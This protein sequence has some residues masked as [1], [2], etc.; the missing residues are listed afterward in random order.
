MT[1][2]RPSCALDQ[3]LAQS[4]FAPQT[5]LDLPHASAV[6]LVVVADQMKKAVQRKHSPLGQLGVS[7]LASLAAGDPAGDDDVAKDSG[8]APPDSGL[9]TRGSGLAARKTQ[10][11][12]RS[13]DPAEAAI[14]PLDVSVADDGHADEPSSAR[15]RNPREPASQARC[16]DAAAACVR[17]RHPDRACMAVRIHASGCRSRWR[18]PRTL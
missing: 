7:R 1:V 17:H 16:A 13:V 12:C 18:T 6:A 5:S 10:D 4:A 11:I 9:G 14:Q 8:L 3:P 2:P 15:R